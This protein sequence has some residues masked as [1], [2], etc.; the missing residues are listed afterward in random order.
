MKV[1]GEPTL[2][3]APDSIPEKLLVSLLLILTGG[4]SGYEVTAYVSVVWKSYVLL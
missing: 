1:D 4:T 2:G 3:I